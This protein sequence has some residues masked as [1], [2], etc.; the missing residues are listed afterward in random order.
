MT[1]NGFDDS[2]SL[3]FGNGMGQFAA[4][5]TLAVPTDTNSGNNAAESVSVGDF[6]GDGQLDLAVGGAP[7]FI[8][9]LGNGDGTFGSPNV[10]AP[11]YYLVR[12]TNFADLD[13]DGSAEILGT[14]GDADGGL[15]EVLWHTA[16][17][18]VSTSTLRTGLQSLSVASK[19]LNGDGT[20]DVVVGSQDGLVNIFTNGCP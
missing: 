20:P 2:V 6:N 18:G 8:T 15:L 19:D 4:G 10:Y 9:L 17:G 1:A 5:P 12:F 14:T 3:F 7:G 13:G 11:D 16:G